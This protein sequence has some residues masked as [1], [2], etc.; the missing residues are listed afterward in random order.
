MGA[1]SCRDI[2]DMAGVRVLYRRELYRC[3]PEGLAGVCARPK[4]LN[5]EGERLFEDTLSR[6]GCDVSRGPLLHLSECGTKLSV[7][8]RGAAEVL[9]PERTPR[10]VCTASI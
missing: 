3:A 7:S 10:P 5:R 2:A 8:R 9:P 1:V 6:L 4:C